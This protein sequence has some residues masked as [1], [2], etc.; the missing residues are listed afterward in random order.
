MMIEAANNNLATR[1][2]S[3]A[4]FVN[5]NTA[6]INDITNKLRVKNSMT[7]PC[8]AKTTTNFKRDPGGHRHAPE[9]AGK[10]AL[11]LYGS[12]RVSARP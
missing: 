4:M 10:H 1:V 6:A 3:A 9:A 11:G 2:E 12:Q 7:H 5:P 8:T